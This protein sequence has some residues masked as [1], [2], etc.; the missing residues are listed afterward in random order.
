MTH[1]TSAKEVGITPM[2]HHYSDEV[3]WYI[4]EVAHS[5]ESIYHSQEQARNKQPQDSYQAISSPQWPTSPN[6]WK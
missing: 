3:H 6:Y 1:H 2:I 5:H 4:L